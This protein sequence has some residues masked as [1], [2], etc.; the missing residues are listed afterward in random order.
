MK[1]TAHPFELSGMGTGPYTECGFYAL[2]SASLASQNPEA[3]NN[4]L[5]NAPRNLVGGVGTCR[6]CGMGISNIFIV[7]DAQGRKY[8]VGSDCVLKTGDKALANKVKVTLAIKARESRRAKLEAKRAAD[9]FEWEHAI[10]NSRGET[11]AQRVVREHE[12]AEKARLDASKSVV[13]K[14][15]FLLD[16][17]Q[18]P[19][20]GFCDSIAQGIRNGQEPRGRAL[21]ICLEI[22]AKSYGRR[23]SKAFEEAHLRAEKLLGITE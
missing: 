20:G 16:S 5:A 13:L 23:G 17:L 2:P 10:C 18:G 12:E 9:R 7:Q 22:Y 8:G 4:A 21:D 19:Q 6:H 3:Y 14:Y 1:T 15:G 11:N